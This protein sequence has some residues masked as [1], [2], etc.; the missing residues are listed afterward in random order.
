ML[1]RD[2]CLGRCF[3]AAG[4]VPTPMMEGLE[5]GLGRFRAFHDIK[6]GLSP[7][8]AMDAL[9][10]AREGMYGI[11]ASAAQDPGGGALAPHEYE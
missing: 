11:A 10:R 5:R 9:Q 7:A 3:A 6:S 1:G 8:V 2:L 4:E